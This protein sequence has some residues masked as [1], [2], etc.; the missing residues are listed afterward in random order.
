[1]AECSQKTVTILTR[2]DRILLKIYQ[3]FV[4][5]LS[6]FL[7]KILLKNF[8]A[9]LAQKLSRLFWTGWS[10]WSHH[11]MSWL[12]KVR[13]SH[14]YRYHIGKTLMYAFTAFFPAHFVLAPFTAW[15]AL[16]HH[17]A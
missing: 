2:I 3:S 12:N 9:K 5:N 16:F 15:D 13:L 7:V 14:N 10:E 1:L 6:E 8:W 17:G 11:N 4:K